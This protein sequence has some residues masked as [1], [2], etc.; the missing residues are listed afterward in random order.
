MGIPATDENVCPVLE[1]LKRH[2]DSLRTLL[3]VMPYSLELFIFLNDQ[4]NIHFKLPIFFVL[5]LFIFCHII[6]NSFTPSCVK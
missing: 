2:H 1:H 5:L 3:L 6:L 4:K